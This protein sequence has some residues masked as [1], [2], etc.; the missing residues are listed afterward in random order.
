VRPTIE[1]PLHARSSVEA[2][3]G[4]IGQLVAMHHRSAGDPE[5]LARVARAAR[6]AGDLLDHAME[7]HLGWHPARN[8]S[9]R[10]TTP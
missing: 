10:E 6:D 7:S 9:G 1:T 5:A 4:W 2:I 3:R 8:D